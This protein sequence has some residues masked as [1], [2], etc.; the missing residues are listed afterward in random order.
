MILLIAAQFGA[1]FLTASFAYAQVPGGGKGKASLQLLEKMDAGTSKD[2]IV[3][4]D[5]SATQKEAL[6]LQSMME[7]PARHDSIIE[8]KAARYAEKKQKVHSAFGSHEATVLKHYSHLPLSFVRIHSRGAL[9]KLLAHPGVVGVYENTVKRL[10]L[11]ESLPL[12]GQTQVAAQGNLGAGTSVAV[13]DT[14]VDYTHSAF[15]SCITTG[16]PASC[17]VVYAQD[18]APGDAG[19]HG[20]NVAGIV[21]AVAPGTKIV[22]L[23]V[24]GASTTSDSIIIEAMNWVIANK[25]TYNL[26]AMNLSLGGGKY[27][28]PVTG[29]PYYVAVHNARTAGILTIA[30]AGND[31]YTDALSQ[32]AATL[33][34]ISVGAVY[35]SPMGQLNWDT[36]RCQDITTAADKVACFSNSAPFLTLLAPGSQIRAAGITM[37]GTSQ[38][39]PHVAGAVAVLRAAFP[40]ETLDQTV[41]RLTN[42]VIVTDSRNTI[43]KPRLNLPMAIG[44]APSCTYAISE[45][46]KSFGSNSSAGS[47]AVTTGFGCTWNAASNTSSSSWLTVTSGN[48]GSGNGTV[49]YALSENPN[50]TP[51]TGTL[52]VAGKIYTVIQSGDVGPVA[53]ILLNSG[54]ESGPVSWAE[55]T[56]NG[57]PV[58]T[59]YLKPTATN[60]WYAWLC[61]YDNCVDNLY[62]DVAIPT[63]AQE[64]IINFKY[65]INTEETTSATVYDSMSVRIFS[66]PNG[67]AYRTCLPLS[68]LNATTDWVQ[69]TSCNL[70]GY[71]GQTIRVQFIAETDSILS[72]NF[73]IDDVTLMVSWVNYTLTVVKAG[74]GSGTVTSN[75]VGI[76]CG[77]N[78]SANFVKGAVV[79]I[80]AT[81]T[82][83][84]T[85]AGWSGVC[86]GTGACAVTMDAAKSVTATFI[87]AVSGGEEFPLGGV[88]PVGWVQ[89]SGSNAAWVG[90]N[91]AA[92][93]GN[94]SLKS[95]IID[96]SQKSEISYTFNFSAGNVSFARKV[97]SE[98]NYDFLEFYIDGVS[99]G[100][101]SGEVA[102]SVVNFPVAAGTHT[103][104]WRY[105]KDGSVSSGGDAAWIDSVLL[106]G[107]SAPPEQALV[108]R[109]FV[110]SYGLDSNTAFSCNVT[111]PC[112]TFAHAVTVVNTDGEVVAL[113][114][115]GYGLVTPIRSISLMAAPGVYAGMS[116]F[117]DA[118]G[119]TIATPGVNVVLRGLTINGQG[120]DSGV[121]MFAGGK[122]SIE[123]CVISNFNGINQH[124]IFVNT[125]ATVRI[126]DTLIRDNSV[127]IGLQGGATADISKSKFLGNNNGILVQSVAA[128]TTTAAISNTVVTGGGT[129]IE[130]F[131]GTSG[132]ARIN[133]VRSAISNN[134]VEGIVA[135]ATAGTA[136]ITLNKSMVSGNAIGFYKGTGG[137]LNSLGN[138][139]ITDNS[140][141]TGTLTLITPK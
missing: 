112:R 1:F 71:K 86:T 69:S 130:A 116:V 110:A 128:I 16:S 51:R 133:V 31:G 89:P 82:T 96:N 37:N 83:G 62:Q 119:V 118:S 90:T 47:I 12:I 106:P 76:A 35:D 93:A 9:D 141:N 72:T 108:Q 137:T 2:F 84:S 50:T 94:L 102:W 54:F 45:T 29:D 21:A 125:G 99:K 97:S 13:L 28:S 20:T 19:N 111:H 74:T 6:V 41:A 104:L 53:N 33:G 68:N 95:G 80:T 113:N 78:C 66:P 140:S 40:G 139:T 135:S 122:L 42:G 115:A 36:S 103:L 18:F 101:W 117:P 49:S 4:Y 121:S 81:P 132:N 24:F 63:D 34:V 85:F 120:G 38:A 100:S 57:Y 98:S 17:K 39:T 91:D 60:S 26:V 70:I 131:S 59:A 127:G 124:G 67:S 23:K 88:I 77:T 114:S 52:T 105:K 126:V 25:S 107:G 92:Y 123:N 75:P 8:L 44:V 65:W 109:A 22:D 73:F 14:G 48:S 5:D 32:P 64:A 79:T 56:A 7:L 10:A 43:A 129:G 11:A 138:N 61:G 55:Q 15:G 30:A 136:S 46:G 27:I 3:I 58:I 87:N 134:T